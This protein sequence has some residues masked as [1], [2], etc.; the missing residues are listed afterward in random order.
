MTGGP[1]FAP[2]DAQC[3]LTRARTRIVLRALLVGSLQH[4]GMLLFALFKL[5]LPGPL[6]DMQM[7]FSAS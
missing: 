4:Q 1:G 2:E 7:I 5:Q 6:C 3:G